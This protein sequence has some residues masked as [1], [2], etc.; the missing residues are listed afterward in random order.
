MK[1]IM[2][3]LVF[4]FC[5]TNASADVKPLEDTTQNRISEANRHL[6]VMPPKEGASFLQ[7]A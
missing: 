4:S 7:N 5:A 3:L 1:N 6:A 2:L